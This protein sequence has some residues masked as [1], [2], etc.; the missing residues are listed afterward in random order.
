MTRS[1]RLAGAAVWGSLLACCL[2][3]SCKV[4][5]TFVA[6]HEPVPDRYAGATD[7]G[8]PGAPRPS[9]D[10]PPNSFWWQEFHDP[11]L[12]DLEKQAA[13]GNLDLKAAYLRIVEARV[14]VLSAQ[15]QGLPTLSAVASFNREQLGIAGIL[16]SKGIAT[17]GGT[18][19]A[20]TS[21]LL[22]SLE[23]PV[24]IYQLGFDASWELDLFGKVRRGV[25]GAEAQSAGAVEARND[26]FVSLE[27]EV[28]QTYL[29]LRAGQMLR[30]ITVDLIAAQRDVTTLTTSRQVHGLAS[31]ADVQSAIGQLSS[32]EAQLPAYDQTIA[33]SK[34]A[35]AVLTGQT[36]EALDLHFNTAH[37][38]PPPPAVVPVGLP[39]SLARRRP[40]IRRAED[41]LHAAT[42]QVGVAVASFYPDVSLSGTPGQR[43]TS[44]RY[45]F[46]WSSHFYTFGPKV[47]IPI[48]AGGA[49]VAN[50]RVTR[51]QAAEAALDYRKTV[52]SALQDVEDGLTELATDA[53]RSAALKDTVAA[54]QR[55]L[56]VDLDAYRHGLITY[57]SVLTVQIQATQARQQLAQALLTQSTDVVKLFKAL[58]GGWEG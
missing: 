6:P 39:S 35:L 40:D 15:A 21:A 46:D 51:A 54:D 43:N 24:N 34:H 17:T 44:T 3:A 32:L 31:E 45:L 23:A 38:L 27:A 56:E 30:Q 18:T 36:P 13:Q 53:Q 25:E 22:T 10:A 8:V 20:S 50:V 14:E 5:P 49:L 42:A 11:E 2:L 19:S 9:S 29:Q 16:K 12:D 7:T 47:S 1:P 55:A 52:L 48:F 57:I 33:V 28:A 4:G 37:D 58:G 41:A 26:L